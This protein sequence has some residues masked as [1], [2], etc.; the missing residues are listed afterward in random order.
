MSA[1]FISYASEDTE[2]VSLSKKIHSWLKDWRYDS[3]FLD[4]HPQDGIHPGNDWRKTLH[5][6]LRD[7][8]AVIAICSARYKESA[9]CVGE[10]SIA[11][12]CGKLVIPI[13]LG[14]KA[15]PIIL[16]DLQAI[17]LPDAITYKSDDES[18]A[19]KQLKKVLDDSLSWRDRHAWDKTKSPFPGLSP[20]DHHLAMV[21]FGR[22]G[23]IDQVMEKI[24]VSSGNQS[25]F[26]LLLG[27]SGCGKSSLVRAGIVPRLKYDQRLKW[28]VLEPFRPGK[29][30][31]VDLHKS[32]SRCV[33]P[34]TLS[35]CQKPLTCD[36]MLKNLE[37]VR[38]EC[39]SED[40]T[41]VVVIDE[42]EGLFLNEDECLGKSNETKSNNGSSLAENFLVMLNE[43]LI[44][45]ESKII[46]IGA[47][48]IN[49]YNMFQKKASK[50]SGIAHKMFLAP[51]QKDDFHKVIEGP[52]QSAGLDLE[53]GLVDR[54]V[55]DTGSG[56]ALPLLAFTLK[57]MWDN[58]ALRK[59]EKRIGANGKPYDFTIVDY[60][61]TGGLDRSVRVAAEK[62]IDNHKISE[63][64]EI[65]LRSAFLHHLVGIK[66]DGTFVKRTANI[67]DLPQK[68]RPI[69]AHLQEARILTDGSEENTIE[70]THD[71]L[72][73]VW[74]LLLNWLEEKKGLISEGKRIEEDRQEWIKSSQ[75][76]KATFL[77]R[78]GRLTRAIEYLKNMESQNNDLSKDVK[79]YITQSLRSRRLKVALSVILAF[80]IL[81][82][83]L[84]ACFTFAS[85]REKLNTAH[86][87]E[88]KA[89]HQALVES[90]PVNSVIYGLAAASRLL[91]T[92]DSWQKSRLSV[93]L[94]KAFYSFHS[95][96]RPIVASENNI[97]S[98]V[99]LR[100][101]NI[102]VGTSKGRIG[103]VSKGASSG[104]ID[105]RQITQTPISKIYELDNGRLITV[106]NK[107]VLRHWNNADFSGESLP[108]SSDQEII[109][110]IVQLKNGDI[111]TGGN[112]GT[113]KRWDS[114]T[115]KLLD[116]K[117]SDQGS[118]LTLLEL[119][120]GNYVSGG[121]DGTLRFW[122]DENPTNWGRE[123]I[124]TPPFN[125]F[126]GRYPSQFQSRHSALSSLKYDDHVSYNRDTLATNQGEVWSLIE[127][128]NG[129]L[130]TGG[131]DGSIRFW[132]DG[133][134]V[135][136]LPPIQSKQG[137]VLSLLEMK[138]GEL[139]SLGM[140]G[141]LRRWS[142]GRSA[143]CNYP[144]V[145][146][147]GGVRIIVKSSDGELLT[148]GNDGTLRYWQL[149][150]DE[151]HG[152]LN[153]PQ[154]NVSLALVGLHD[155]DLLSGDSKG[156]IHKLHVEADVLQSTDIDTNEKIAVWS[157]VELDD[158]RLLSMNSKGSI[159]IFGKGTMEE[160]RL[161]MDA[162]SIP[163]RMIRL[164]NGNF[165]TG[166]LDGELRI[167]GQDLE[168]NPI[169][170]VNSNQGAILSLIQLGNGSVVSGG[171][172]GSI[173]IWS[174]EQLEGDVR[175]IL[176]GQESIS[177]LLEL[178]NKDLLTGSTDGT[179]LRWRDLHRT[180]DGYPLNTE[181]QG[182]LGLALTATGEIISAGN[183]GSIKRLSLPEVVNDICRLRN[184]IVDHSSPDIE[185]AKEIAMRTCDLQQRINATIPWKKHARKRWLITS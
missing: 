168:G 128:E 52:A 74:P 157:I 126:A 159:K 62:V 156:L 169:R 88:Y 151:N 46:I 7:S 155:G 182:I 133:E 68:S 15:L 29:D 127:L 96:A 81:L 103:Q 125:F 9:W 21:F 4:K 175:V 184:V 163:I 129:V 183:D 84:V 101:G 105:T 147:Q 134:P 102:L 130:A 161:A 179:I 132:K 80:I 121:K 98:L 154:S 13:L 25:A 110:C 58:R 64:E 114:E 3:V 35:P 31:F 44:R 45:E 118:I 37:A 23:D 91:Q 2:A 131:S 69:L 160:R 120:N 30:P 104:F 72:L 73:R 173:R 145:T 94:S 27:A 97:L 138:N 38:S 79:E 54:L 166:D 77:L 124:T 47:L 49:E 93:S 158:D 106:D 180:E 34:Q 76:T 150:S 146:G 139:L 108:T 10:V 8:R 185:D 119:R 82:A 6:K 70:L 83:S 149:G 153:K 143:D 24:M 67:D 116:T 176:T 18:T 66:S 11:I 140:D 40:T 63:E 60:E 1:I 17:V 20:F 22:D 107:Q 92:E 87:A 61:D 165:L 39:G 142:N 162:T 95:T 123:P 137:G 167:Y 65:A 141:S 51:L 86:I 36:E 99:Q 71:A 26:L 171:S 144:I 135:Q 89:L 12:Y 136:T 100:S 109:H 111:L 33:K 75:Q 90:N 50:L 14:T 28:I 55:T 78:G 48:R 170:K 42:L 85:N 16:D 5:Q 174:N 32:L 117:F 181:Q 177:S 122:Y 172:D 41:I 152:Y 148:G 115:L 57:Q 112:D 178:Q 59:G 43:L 113:I 164:N 19:R 53:P 56:D